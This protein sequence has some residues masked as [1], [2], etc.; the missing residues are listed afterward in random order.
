MW[1]IGTALLR[2]I[3]IALVAYGIVLLIAVLIAGPTRPA[4][5]LRQ[6][7]A[8]SLRERP[9]I[10]YGGVAVVFLL[11][12]LWGPTEGTRTA[13]GVVILAVLAVLGVWALRRETM[14]EF[15]PS[16]T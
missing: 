5:W 11:V 12:L 7:L 9:W 6:K 8:P 2:D 4:R 15:P 3:A 1:V 10:V 13:V 14:K 16:T